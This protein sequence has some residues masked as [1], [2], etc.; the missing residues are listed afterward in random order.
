MLARFEEQYEAH[1][2]RL[3]RLVTSRRRPARYELVEIAGCRRALAE[4]ARQLQLMADR[5]YGRCGQCADDIPMEWLRV[6]P[7]LRY[8]PDCQARIPA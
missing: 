4:T 5:D 7:D 3:A 2:E 1:T 8:C 6:R